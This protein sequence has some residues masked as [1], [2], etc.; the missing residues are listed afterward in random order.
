MQPARG[1]C[2]GVDGPGRL[3][4]VVGRGGESP[5]RRRRPGSLPP[6]WPFPLVPPVGKIGRGDRRW[7]GARAG[8]KKQLLCLVPEEEDLTSTSHHS[9]RTRSNPWY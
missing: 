4:R 1:V 9:L 8:P 6:P 2:S 5:G 7:G 3:V